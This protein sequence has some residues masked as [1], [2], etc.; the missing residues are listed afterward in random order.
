MCRQL[1]GLQ[2]VKQQ[3]HLALRLFHGVPL[4]HLPLPLVGGAGGW[5]RGSES[6]AGDAPALVAPR[7]C[8]SSSLQDTGQD[9]D[10][11]RPSKKLLPSSPRVMPSTQIYGRPNSVPGTV[12]GAGVT[13]VSKT[14][15]LPVRNSHPTGRQT[16][17][18]RTQLGASAEVFAPG[19]CPKRHQEQR[20]QQQIRPWKS[21]QTR[22]TCLDNMEVAREHEQSATVG[23]DAGAVEG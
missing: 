13:E 17:R 2:V 7:S 10:V 20:R 21:P 4:G 19:V 1:Q 5:D 9:T 15:F 16:Q 18:N 12:P 6:F 22:H 14:Q 8:H 3:G 11:S 23:M